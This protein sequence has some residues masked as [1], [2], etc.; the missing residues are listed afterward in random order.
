[1]IM[2]FLTWYHTEESRQRENDGNGTELRKEVEI[3]RRGYVY[4]LR[5]IP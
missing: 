1:M 3:R 2:A 4:S 5:R